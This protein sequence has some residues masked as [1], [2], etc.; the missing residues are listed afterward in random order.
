MCFYRFSL[1]FCFLLGTCI[2][3]IQAQEYN[4]EEPIKLSGKINSTADELLP[5]LSPDNRLYFS[6]ANSNLN[7]GGIYSRNQIW[8]YNLNSN[9]SLSKLFIPNG[10]RL[11]GKNAYS[12]IGI[13]DRGNTVFLMK[14][15]LGKKVKGIYFSKVVAGQL[16]KPEL[17]PIQGLESAEFISAYVSPDFEVILF[18]LDQEG[19]FGKEDIYISVKNVK[20]DWSKIRNLGSV[21]NT[22]GFEM[23]PFL[24]TDKN[25]LFFSSEGHSSLGRADIFYSER[26]YNSWETWSVPKRLPAPLNSEAFDAYFSIYPDS[27]CYFSS[28]RHGGTMDIYKSKLIKG[29]Q[30][31][32]DAY[33]L[34]EETKSILTE[35]RGGQS[36]IKMH[37]MEI[38]SIARESEISS[39]VSKIVQKMS[40]NSRLYILSNKSILPQ[41]DM[42]K[43]AQIF[44]GMGLNPES[45]DI[46]DRL[47]SIYNSEFQG[48]QSILQGLQDRELLVVV[49]SH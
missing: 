39:K 22:A 15:T 14:N 30:N 47:H 17:I 26:L 16:I 13:S 45:I 49:V 19:G 34:I 29:K 6:R 48:F 36:S 3:S 44:L 38:I 11:K 7:L 37:Q 28:D 25:T 21:I 10:W 33:K 27:I 20:G 31:S 32:V 23:S 1:I 18:S 40:V 42:S 46:P 8:Y 5:L 43:L 4:F 24:S 12:I 41:R 9:E 2:F 35:L